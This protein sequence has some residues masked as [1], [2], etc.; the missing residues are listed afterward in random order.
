MSVE[1]SRSAARA[2]DLALAHDDR[3]DYIAFTRLQPPLVSCIAL[4]GPAEA[5]PNSDV[6]LN[7]PKRE[8]DASHCE[9]DSVAD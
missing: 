5:L 1:H 8:K 9:E 2:H 7:Q 6:R 3:A 4:L